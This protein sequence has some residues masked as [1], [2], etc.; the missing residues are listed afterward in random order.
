M[1]GWLSRE[2]CWKK[3]EAAGRKNERLRA[4]DS[5]TRQ[6][7]AGG[8]GVRQKEQFVD[9]SGM[10]GQWKGVS[11][12]KNWGQGLSRQNLKT[13]FTHKNQRYCSNHG[14]RC[15]RPTEAFR[16]NY[17]HVITPMESPFIMLLIYAPN[18]FL[19]WPVPFE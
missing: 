3:L 4:V 13:Q 9:K 16:G 19:T 17:A 7:E 2:N 5:E 14:G 11:Q 18:I 8:G 1:A 10:C 15:Q 12:P 6:P